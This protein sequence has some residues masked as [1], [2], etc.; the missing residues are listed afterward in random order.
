M[1]TKND[2]FAAASAHD[3]WGS[4]FMKIAYEPIPISWSV[5]ETVGADLY[6]YLQLLEETQ[7]LTEEAGP[8]HSFLAAQLGCEKAGLA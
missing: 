8:N 6:V 1:I 2:Y 3:L 4:V 7:G 5:T